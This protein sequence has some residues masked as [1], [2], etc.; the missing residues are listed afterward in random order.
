M[1]KCKVIRKLVYKS[2]NPIERSYSQLENGQ[3]V[4][5][6]QRSVYQECKK[7][8]KNMTKKQVREY[9]TKKGS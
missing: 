3:V 9:L 1:K 2:D 7:E 4:A 5:D 6:I 8:C